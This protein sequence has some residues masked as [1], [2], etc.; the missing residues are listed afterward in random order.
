[1]S[2][3]S[4]LVSGLLAV[5]FAPGLAL[6]QPAP[7][8]AP[9]PK[10]EPTP[11]PRARVIVSP[12]GL[13]A[14]DCRGEGFSFGKR[15]YLG[16]EATRITG[17]LRRHFGAPEAA[18][19]LVSRVVEG[20]P[21]DRAGIEVGDVLVRCADREVGVPGDLRAAVKGREG[22]ESVAVELF[23]GGQRRQLNVRL[24]E[25]ESCVF[26]L[27]Q[28][29]DPEDLRE[30]D[31]LRGLK[32]E[33]LADL[34]ELEKLGELA[35]L[36]QLKELGIDLKSIDLNGLVKN[37][38]GVAVLGLDQALKNGEWAQHVEELQEGKAEAIEKR[39]EEIAR[40]LEQLERKLEAETGRYG[41]LAKREVERAREDVQ[42]ELERSKAELEKNT[43]EA[44]EKARKFEEE[45]RRQAERAARDAARAGGSGGS[46]GSPEREMI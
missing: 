33:D 7:H 4:R 27:G 30:L 18:G 14:A 2:S 34:K 12:E 9:T 43:R 19:V 10:A 26:D 23:R 32:I 41:E 36:E 3:R 37:A 31:E 13:A 46:G 6:A 45:A 38:V 11:A 1:M 16:V 5:A 40:Q 20:G 8:P 25:K 24:E 29:I 21:A 17:E 42:R 28:V 39:M 22:G 44:A 35:D 15:A